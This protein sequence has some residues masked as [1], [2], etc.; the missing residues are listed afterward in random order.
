MFFGVFMATYAY[1]RVSSL[2]QNL[3]RQLAQFNKL[4][5]DKIFQEKISGKNTK[6]PELNK[7]MD[8]LKERDLVV[9]CSLDRLSRSYDD[10]I[11]L[12]KY[13]TE[14]KKADIKILDMPL[15]DTTNGDN[16]DKLTRKFI[17]DLF[18]QVIAY[19]ANKEREN[20]KERQKQGIEQAKLRGIKMGRPQK[21]SESEFKFHFNRVCNGEISILSLCRELKITPVT[22]YRL[23]EKYDL[24]YEK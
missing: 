6:R 9:V 2:D 3:D 16:G 19:V 11:T 15:L 22:F 13:I 14:E 23:K 24:V 7:M 8:A 5:I 1:A 21:L 12:W 18:L 10:C 4:K 20:I 17:S